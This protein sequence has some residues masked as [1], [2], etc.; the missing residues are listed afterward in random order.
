VATLTEH[1]P[2]GYAPR[3]TGPRWTTTDAGVRRA[4]ADG[5]RELVEVLPD[6]AGAEPF[7]FFFLL[8]R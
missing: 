5:I 4:S 2:D 8:F 3:T 1:I 6:P 7:F